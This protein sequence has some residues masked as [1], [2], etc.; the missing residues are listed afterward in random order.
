MLDENRPLPE[1]DVGICTLPCPS[2]AIC[3]VKFDGAGGM[4]FAQQREFRES[5]MSKKKWCNHERKTS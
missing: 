4:S 2:I 3:T 1:T 5:T